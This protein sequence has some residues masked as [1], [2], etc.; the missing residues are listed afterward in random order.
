MVFYECYFS[1]SDKGELDTDT[2]F[3]DSNDLAK[4]IEKILDK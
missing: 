2:F 3:K 1:L 4:F